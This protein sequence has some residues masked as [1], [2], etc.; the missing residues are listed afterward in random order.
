MRS[1]FELIIT[2]VL[3]IVFWA[4]A[5][6]ALSFSYWLTL[7]ICMP[8][9]AFL[10]R[11][12]LIKHDCGH[13]A[14]FRRRVFNDWV[15]RVLGVLTLTPYDVWRRDHAVHHA[16]SGNLDKRG[17]GDIDTLTVREYRELPRL[18]RIAYQLYRHPFFM[19]VVGPAYYFLLRN[20]LPLGF[21]NADRRFWISAMGTNATIALVGGIMIYFLGVG[22]FL[23]VHLPIT[24]LAATIGVWLFYVQH[25]FEDTVWAEDHAWNSH[26]AALFGSS[27]YELPSVLNWITANIGVHHVHH[28]NSRIPYYR[29]PQVL[30]DFPG[31][32]KNRRLTLMQGFGCMRLRLW[33]EGQRK[34]VSFS[35]ARELKAVATSGL[36]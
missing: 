20:R 25:Q 34:L 23:V 27:H 9:G 3:F 36:K 8:A 18:R 4:A 28:L 5:W 16:T 21:S 1:V 22:P 35:E 30:R 13:G 31:F 32:T 29:L 17:T 26:Y 11:L 6:W 24:L 19:F 15:G 12:F 14:F 10:V 7:A 2:S 33:D